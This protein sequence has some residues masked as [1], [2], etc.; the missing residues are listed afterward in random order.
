MLLVAA[1]L[2]ASVADRR[3]VR[4]QVANSEPDLLK[5]SALWQK[6]ASSRRRLDANWESLVANRGMKATKRSILRR[7]GNPTSLPRDA[8]Y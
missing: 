6:E 5:I 3:G 1:T 2:V 4:Y 8:R 7:S